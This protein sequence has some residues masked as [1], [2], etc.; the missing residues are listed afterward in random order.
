[1]RSIF[2]VCAQ[3]GILPRYGSH[4]HAKPLLP[5]QPFVLGDQIISHQEL[6]S[7]ELRTCTRQAVLSA[8][9]DPDTVPHC[10]K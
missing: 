6:D 2:T 9:L 5:K 4:C 10:R 7:N 8:I 1:M 3:P